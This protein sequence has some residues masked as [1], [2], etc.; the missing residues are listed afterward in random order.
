M[1]RRFL[2]VIAALAF[3]FGAATVPAD[4][5]VA[6]GADGLSTIYCTAHKPPSS[7][8]YVTHTYYY[9]IQP[10]LV[11]VHCEAKDPNVFAGEW[12]YFVRWVP[13]N[14]AHWRQGGYFW[15]GSFHCEGHI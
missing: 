15:C 7:T 13:S 10:D 6:H 12:E 5:A 2:F 4:T 9:S 1:K 11:T 14:G 3:V 8:S